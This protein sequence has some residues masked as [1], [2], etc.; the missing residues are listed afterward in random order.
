[1]YGLSPISMMSGMMYSN[2]M[3]SS[4]NVNNYL[5]AKYGCQD[6]NI[7]KDVFLKRSYVTHYPKNN[8]YTNNNKNFFRNLIDF[9]K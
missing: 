4:G 3:Y 5:N 8:A 7:P 9:F 1:M 6:C 2:P